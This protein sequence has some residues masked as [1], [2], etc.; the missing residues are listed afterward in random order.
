MPSTGRFGR[1]ALV[2]VTSTQFAA[3]VTPFP[4]LNPIHAL[5]SFV[6]AIATLLYFGEYFTWLM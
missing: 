1:T 3:L 6:P 5:P 2:P 4:R